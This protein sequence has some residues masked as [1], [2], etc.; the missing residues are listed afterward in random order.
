MSCNE[1]MSEEDWNPL[2]MRN[3][4]MLAVS[5]EVLL[6]KQ[7]CFKCKN[8]KHAS[9]LLRLVPLLPVGFCCI[10]LDHY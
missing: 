2:S 6:I 5:S 4:Q 10:K 9:L 8:T 7:V 1:V 3:S